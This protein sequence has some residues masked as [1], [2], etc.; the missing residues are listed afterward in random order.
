MPSSSLANRCR[1]ASNREKD[2]FV[3]LTEGA[4]EGAWE[5]STRREDGSYKLNFFK[6]CKNIAYY[7]ARL[8]QC[9]CH[10]LRTEFYPREF[11]SMERNN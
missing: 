6:G 1:R 4:R 2:D 11:V 7:F 5:D 8:R 9:D 10:L 3:T